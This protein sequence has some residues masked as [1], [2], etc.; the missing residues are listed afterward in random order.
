MGGRAGA[1]TRDRLKQRRA[2]AVQTLRAR[3]IVAAVPF[4]APALRFRFETAHG[5]GR[6][7][8][9]H[10]GA[11]IAGGLLSVTGAVID[12]LA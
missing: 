9:E 8:I 4:E 10:A 1:L 2:A 3:R 11:G 7:H 6:F 12:S 5:G